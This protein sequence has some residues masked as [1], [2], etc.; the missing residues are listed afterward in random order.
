MP[1]ASLLLEMP[2]Y[3]PAGT[4]P[5]FSVLAWTSIKHRTLDKDSLADLRDRLS[6]VRCRGRAFG[7]GRISPPAA[8]LGLTR[9]MGQTAEHT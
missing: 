4:R 9:D 2:Q 8:V 3:R 5:A 6:E 1:S 7:F